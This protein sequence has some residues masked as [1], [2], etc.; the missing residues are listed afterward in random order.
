M[1]AAVGAVCLT[2]LAGYAAD[3]PKQRQGDDE[4]R[5]FLEASRNEHSRPEDW[6]PVQE[7]TF[8]DAKAI[9]PMHITKGQWVVRDGQL[10]AIG[11][12]GERSILIAPC[13]WDAVRIAFDAV[14]KPGADGRVGDIGIR[15]DADAKTGSF[16]KGYTMI[17]SQYFNQATVC[18]RLSQPIARTEWSPIVPG[19]THH[20]VMEFT[21]NPIS[22]TR[23]EG[24][25]RLWVDQRV[26]LD[27][28]DRDHPLAMDASRW[29]GLSTYR[30]EMSVDNLV[31]SAPAAKK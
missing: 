4:M 28:W 29:I 22:K 6:K 13:Q 20:I 7:F 18:Y 21:N 8:D 26:V 9:A 17:T 2:A 11:G 10:L 25:L 3:G 31:I 30:T 16:S 23:R 14:L 19:R 24:H 12:E 15:L 27:A 1:L 5:Q